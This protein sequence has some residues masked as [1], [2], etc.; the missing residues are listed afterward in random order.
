M[1][2][3]DSRVSSCRKSVHNYESSGGP[4]QQR[5]V[6]FI[7]LVP[8]HPGCPRQ[9]AVKRACV[10]VC[11]CYIYIY[12]LVVYIVC[13]PTFWPLN[14]PTFQCQIAIETASVG[15]M[16]R[17]TVGVNP[18]S[19]SDG[20]VEG[21]DAAG[22]TDLPLDRRQQDT[23]HLHADPRHGLVVSVPVRLRTF[24]LL[25]Q[26]GRLQPSPTAHG[27]VSPVLVWNAAFKNSSATRK[28]SCLQP[29][30]Q[31]RLSETI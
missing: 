16:R 17:V 21:L 4:V 26:Q 8:A 25:L 7:F 9:R 27:E 24:L 3:S 28:K 1:F 14:A 6:G 2:R 13:F 11:A 22:D 12:C 29:R 15:S 18:E 20:R 23:H 5:R 30:I 19:R 31:D 10:C